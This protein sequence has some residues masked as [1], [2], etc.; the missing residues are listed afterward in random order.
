VAA[1][2]V[3][4]RTAFPAPLDAENRRL[5]RAIGDFLAAHQ[6]HPSP[7]NYALVYAFVT[8]RASPAAQAILAATSDGVRL[9]QDE[10]DRIRRETGAGPDD[11]VR[12]V[13]SDPEVISDAR[14][15]VEEFSS[16][17]EATQAEAVSY[18]RELADGA[19]ELTALTPAAP[20]VAGI[21]RITGAMLERTRSAETQLQAAREEAQSLR[22][23]L[24]EAEEEARSDPLT[25]LP[26]RR[27]F[28]D[29]L[30]ELQ[31]QGGVLSLA[32]CDIDRFKSVND[33]H[34]HGV[35]DRVLRMVAHVLS[36]SCAGHMVA[37]IGGE[38]FV[39]LFEGLDCAAAAAVLEEARA[40][41]A[42]RHFKVRGTDAALGRITFSAGVV[43]CDP[44]DEEPP[45]KRADRLLY[46]AKNSGRNM[47]VAEA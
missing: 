44:D 32:I 29:R 20:Q 25:R 35:G 1:I 17:V 43:A 26:N 10:A 5:F 34:G 31:A 19:A 14:R 6:L 7:D 13:V 16:I 15:Q 30:A 47:V 3:E 42:G 40:E 12:D 23:K 37:R 8:D 38:E 27:A 28:E 9:S 36:A 2:E 39:V 45:L 4:A 21:V 18:G 41:L 22:E 46:Q 33:T 24:A 11:L